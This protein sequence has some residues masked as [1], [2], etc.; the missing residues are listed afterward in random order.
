MI[1]ANV[2]NVSSHTLTQRNDISHL[3]LTHGMVNLHCPLFSWHFICTAIKHDMT[4]LWLW[5][6]LIIKQLW[7]VSVDIS[8]WYHIGLFQT[9]DDRLWC[10]HVSDPG[11]PR[12]QDDLQDRQQPQQTGRH[13][14]GIRSELS[15]IRSGLSVI[16]SGHHKH[17]VSN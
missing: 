11:A 13:I 15:V 8:W 7:L 12:G 16:R 17:Q 14:T 4:T 3:Q 5:F 9:S 2:T 6:G 10:D 1:K